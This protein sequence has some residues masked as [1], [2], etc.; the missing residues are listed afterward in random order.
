MSAPLSLWFYVNA[1]EVRAACAMCAPRSTGEALRFVLARGVEALEAGAPRAPLPPPASSRRQV[2]VEVS[3]ELYARVAA[4]GGAR[5][6]LC[7]GLDALD[8]EGAR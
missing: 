4:Q 2:G 6:C 7:A 8:A 3:A 5:V 1:R